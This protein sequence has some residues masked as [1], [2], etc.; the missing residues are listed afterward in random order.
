VNAH[1]D[2]YESL[3]LDK[4]SST[5]DIRST[6]LETLEGLKRDGVAAHDARVQE[7]SVALSVLGDDRIRS[8]YDGRLTDESAPRMGIPEL[9][10]LASTGA[11]PDE[12]AQS[13]GYS[14]Q[15][16]GAHDDQA[17]SVIPAVNGSG[18]TSYPAGSP[19]SPESSDAS[20]STDSAA[21]TGAT[22]SGAPAGMSAPAFAG[23]TA[24]SSSAQHDS[25]QPYQPQQP[26]QALQMGQM[27]QAQQRPAAA[28]GSLKQLMDSVPGTAKGLVFTLAGIG[29]F[30]V[31]MTLV[32]ILLMLADSYTSVG[33]AVVHLL[34]VLL[35][36]FLIPKVLRG[37]DSTAIIPLT[38]TPIAMAIM[39]LSSSVTDVVLDLSRSL[40]VTVGT[41]LF[42]AWV[43]VAVLALLPDT[44][45]WLA[46]NYVAK[47]KPVAPQHGAP[48]YG[49]QSQYGQQQAPQFGGQQYGQQNQQ[50]QQQTP[51][52]GAQPYG[53]QQYGQFGQ[54]GQQ[55]RQGQ[56]PPQFGRPEQ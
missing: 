5:S 50:G 38:V 22:A 46:G 24:A 45:A 29:A 30:G 35:A 14:P 2:F 41:L 4:D 19:E 39:Y 11:F 56:Q 28:P 13:A 47:P 12:P 25:P 40:S 51:Q 43:A 49:Q 31:L 26:Q 23:A 20:G 44:R 10:A 9:R 54:Y 16:P 21:E 3:G 55:S 42:F 53:E 33:S 34:S 6:I 36:G 27:D 7:N 48:Q 1:Y 8:K 17:T 32:G 15:G 18:E 37:K 52:F